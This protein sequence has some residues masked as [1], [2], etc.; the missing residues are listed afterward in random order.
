MSLTVI[1]ESLDSRAEGLSFQCRGGNTAWC[2]IT[3]LA[4]RDLMD[5]HGI[6]VT[7]IEAFRVLLPEIERLINAK[8]DAVRFE[9][10]GLFIRPIDLLRYGF[11][12]GTK[13][14]A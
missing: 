5:F 13:S 11:Q 10:G 2:G 6:K 9:K 1:L 4:L 8:S 7:E 12:T 3:A 14:A